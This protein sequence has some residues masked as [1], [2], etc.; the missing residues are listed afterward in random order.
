M[1]SELALSMIHHRVS[2]RES[3]E[4][5]EGAAYSLRVLDVCLCRAILLRFDHISKIPA[6]CLMPV[7]KRNAGGVR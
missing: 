7:P 3:S 1:S 5:T 2:W 4:A 6:T